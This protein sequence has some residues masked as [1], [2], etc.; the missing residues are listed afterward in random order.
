MVTQMHAAAVNG[1]KS[2]LSKLLLSEFSLF[3]LSL[4]RFHSFNN[5]GLSAEINQLKF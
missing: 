3:P 5:S 2:Q 4:L 1:D